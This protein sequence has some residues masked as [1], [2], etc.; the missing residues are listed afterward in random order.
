MLCDTP[1]HR[2]TPGTSTSTAGRV[3]ASD[4]GLALAN[5]RCTVDLIADESAVE[6]PEGALVRVGGRSTNEG[7]VVESLEVVHVPSAPRHLEPL[8]DLERSA[9]VVRRRHRART[10]VRRYFE[11]RDFHEVR[12]SHAVDSPGTDPYVE[13]VGTRAPGNE[14][15][16]VP[17]FLHTSP[18]FA[19]KRLLA[20]GV[21]RLY[22]L[23]PVWRHGDDTPWH[24]AEFEMLEWYRAWE[25]VEPVMEDVERLVDRMLEGEATIPA[26]DGEDGAVRRIPIAPPFERVTMRE[27]VDVACGFDLFDALDYSSLRE[28]CVRHDLLDGDVDR[29]HPPTDGRWDELFFELMVTRLEPALADRG[30]VFVTQWPSELAILARKDPEDPRVARRFEL[31]VGGVELANG[32]DELRDPAEQRRRF[33]AD[34]AQRR[35]LDK[36]EL[37]VPEDFLAALEAG[38]PPSA[39]VA[40]GFDRLLMLDLGLSPIERVQL[41]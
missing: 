10:V 4:G 1:L 40:L 37:P 22:Q 14:E 11:A 21:E 33:R 39:G 30:A 6:V 17:P 15:R 20:R 38:L 27:L 18:E 41:P 32:F 28:A 34:N 36:P 13:P 5:A 16:S 19:M 29:R 8:R 2:L 26:A 3:V 24:S 23:S 7:F 12:T 35:D 9:A 31:F 25:G